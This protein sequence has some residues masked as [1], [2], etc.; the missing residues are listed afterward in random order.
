LKNDVGEDMKADLRVLIAE[1]GEKNIEPLLGRLTQGGYR[2]DFLRVES[3]ADLLYSLENQP[4][5]I[6]LC[7]NLPAS[8]TFFA[9]KRLKELRL[10]IPLL[11]IGGAESEETIVEY[12]RQG[13]RDYLRLKDLDRLT[14]AMKRELA[15]AGVRK[16][17]RNVE[18]EW[19]RSWEKYRMIAETTHDLILITN[20]HFEMQ[21]MNKAVRSLLG[22]EPIGHSLIDFTPR[23]LRPQML[24][25]MQKRRNGFSGVL[26]LEW[27]LTD[28]AGRPFI[29]DVQS[30]LLTENTKP[31]G[32]LFMA[33]D[34]TELTR[35]KNELQKAKAAAEA[36]NEA[37]S[38]FLANMSH[39]IRTPMNGII[40]MSELLMD[41]ELT[42]EQKQFAEI[43]H[44][45]SI[46]LL[47]L[48]NDILDLSK[49]EA[50][51]L[52]L[53]I[54]DF[55]LR[56]LLEDIAEM[57]SVSAQDKNLEITAWMEPDVPIGLQGDPGRLR[58]A[59]INLTNNAVKFTK[60]GEITIRV[61]LV[62]EDEHFVTLRF[63]V[64]D[65]GIGIPQERIDALF[66]PFVQADSSTTRQYGGSGL[67][68]AITRQLVE[69][70][71]GQIGCESEVGR[72]STF[73][74]TAVFAKQAHDA[75]PTRPSS[76]LEK[77]KI[78]VVDDHDVSRLLAV[79]LLNGWK[80]RVYDVPDTH[81]ALA[82]LDKAS[83]ENDP[84]EIVL[85]NMKMPG[86]DGEELGRQIRE[87]PNLCT[88]KIILMAV[89]GKKGDLSRPKGKNF[90]GYLTKPI[91]QN[92]LYDA[93]ACAIGKNPSPKTERP[94]PVFTGNE[95]DKTH[96]RS[97]KILV[98]EDNPTGQ[99]VILALL[100]KI[101]YLPDIVSNGYE[102]INALRS[103]PYDLV[104]MDCQMPE[105]DGYE[106]TRLIRRIETGVLNPQV[107]I[108][109][110]TAHALAND[111]NL[112]RE[113][114]MNGYLSKPVQ[115]QTLS[116]SIHYWLA[117]S[118]PAE[119]STGLK[120]IPEIPTHEAE[121]PIPFFDEQDMKERLMDD[122]ELAVA[123]VEGFLKD[124]PKQVSMLKVYLE[125][126]DLA[127][128]RRQAHNIQGAA[129]NVGAASLRQTA[130][131]LEKAAESKMLHEAAALFGQIG[132]QLE[133][134]Q[135][136]L[137]KSQWF[138]AYRKEGKH[139]ED[140]DCRG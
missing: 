82:F 12:L 69:L 6:I 53:E 130:L 5:D 4:W 136:A 74:F 72:G 77:T 101:G 75:M 133:L 42:A 125:K 86:M 73:R 111:R 9:L 40:G 137:A 38:V 87:N 67:G 113:A 49:I 25:M 1:H 140:T 109:A 52:E 41:T 92:Q 19:G 3:R 99:T 90:D 11:I 45:C 89:A 33:R 128:I 26:S 110:V 122:G 84:F 61:S 134:Y 56:V 63:A 81:T 29:M 39:E 126:G 132:E 116:G 59:L 23:E 34:I 119:E 79:T 16:A 66:S 54:L 71:G 88:T 127:G 2:P 98:V 121:G 85:L 36:A 20:L 107:P 10:D 28:T 35:T 21:Y 43:I 14:P 129:A 114:G 95:V 65:T 15:E 32:V 30:H 117:D 27:H 37:K 118:P 135:K 17:L 70:M 103:L 138:N 47:G 24:E 78:L 120:I 18:M 97:E 124:M 93:I 100:K 7:Q 139:H 105:M 46:S 22:G 68:L 57:A 104:L 91:R 115:L 108:I 44:K 106:T 112:Y 50:N 55:S 80:C 48:L 60:Q 123:I 83:A 31:S 131:S 58:Q 102:A 96:F 13:A 8:D 51:K 64:S 76:D 94:S 62:Q